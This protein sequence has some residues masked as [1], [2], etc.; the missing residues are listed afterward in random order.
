[1]AVRTPPKIPAPKIKIAT[2]KLAPEEIPNTNGPAKGFLNSVCI[3]KPAIDKPDPTSIAV[4]ALGSLK[5]R[6]IVAQLDFELSFP[7]KTAMIS[8][9]GM[10]TEPK[11][12]LT[13]KTITNPKESVINC[14]VYDFW[15]I[16]YSEFKNLTNFWMAIPLWEIIFFSSEFISANEHEALL[17]LKIGS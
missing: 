12:M 15:I 2:P 7:N 6:I 8:S 5:W 11:L 14:F 3:N 4:I 16:N 13:N 10:D 17:G 9:R 1:V